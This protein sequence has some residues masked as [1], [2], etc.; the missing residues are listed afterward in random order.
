MA[1]GE[2]R[3]QEVSSRNRIE[4]RQSD[5]QKDDFRAAQAEGQ[6]GGESLGCCEK[7]RRRT[8]KKISSE[9]R[10]WADIKTR[11]YNPNCK[12]YARYGGAGVTM[13]AEWME[14]PDAFIAYIGT[15]PTADH[16]LDRID[17]RGNYEPGNLRWATRLE[18]ARNKRNNIYIEHN[19]ERRL[20]VEWAEYYGLPRQIVYRRFCDGMC[21]DRLFS[22]EHLN[23]VS[24]LRRPGRRNPANVVELNG[25]TVH[26]ADVSRIY[27]INITTLRSRMLAGDRDE[28]LIRPET[29]WGMLEYK[30][31]RKTVLGWSRELGIKT[32]TIYSRIRKGYPTEMILGPLLPT[33]KPY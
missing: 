30:G 32:A 21:G 3:N 27:G 12:A 19:G 13:W 20:L 17:P 4:G 7:K 14:N 15:K 25:E 26:I 5:C 31:Q 23:P 16:T 8:K 24:G 28:E 22:S 9:Y 2:R 18:Q 11:C 33:K 29:E 10:L 6:E 1:S